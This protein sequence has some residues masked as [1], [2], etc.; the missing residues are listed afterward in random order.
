M[1]GFLLDTNIPSEL[2]RARPEPKAVEWIR[3]AADEQ[4]FLSVVTLGEI[5]KGLTIHPDSKRRAQLQH[6]LDTMLRPWATHPP[7]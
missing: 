5:S 6:W 7:D 1:K 3:G 2:I 4:L